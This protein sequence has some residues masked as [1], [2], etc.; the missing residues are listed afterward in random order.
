MTRSDIIRAIAKKFSGLRVGDIDRVV[1][2]INGQIVAAVSAGRRV[3]LRGFGVFSP[4]RLAP[5]LAS[6]PRGGSRIS[7]KDRRSVKFRAGLT[8]NKKINNKPE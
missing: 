6:N 7:L 1:N 3:E 5:K 4:K 2:I 8:L